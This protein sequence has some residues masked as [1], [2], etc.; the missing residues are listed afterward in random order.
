LNLASNTTW[1]LIED[2]IAEMAGLPGQ[3]GLF[4][5]DFFHLGGDEVKTKCWS[6]IS[7]ISEWLAERNMTEDDGYGYFVKRAAEIAR[8]HGV[9][10]VQWEEVYSHFGRALDNR[11]VVH[12]W[13]SKTLLKNVTTDG[14]QA[15]INNL[16]GGDIWYL[17]KL[18][19]ATWS[20]I[21]SNE[22]CQDLD[23]KQCGF[24]LGGQGEMWGET[25][26]ASDLEQTVWPK[27]AAI[28]ER[29]W[30][31][32]SVTDTAIASGDAERRIRF[33]RCLLERRGIAAGPV[34]NAESREAPQGPG[35]CYEQ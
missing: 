17:D 11:T 30:S 10:P 26:D 4:K 21:Y 1:D 14:F 24:V 29:L 5:D 20:S 9:R 13:K 19:R 15:L 18:D 12:V 34:G 35:S 8:A 25:V 28:A 32:R 3:R 16:H 2:L 6:Q 31:P 7:S 27:L 22:P 23:E 33:F